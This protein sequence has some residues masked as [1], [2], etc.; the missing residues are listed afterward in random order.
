MAHK[1]HPRKAKKVKVLKIEKI[2]PDKH[3]VH[4]EVEGMDDPPVPVVEPVVV[5]PPKE[6]VKE[7]GVME[8]LKSLWS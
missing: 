2:E 6:A 8:W 1:K 3:L 7:N 5:H 4:L